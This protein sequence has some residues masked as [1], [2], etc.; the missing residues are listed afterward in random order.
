MYL[1]S[2]K[3]LYSQRRFSWLRL[4]ITLLVVAAGVYIGY[5]L[6]GLF[7][8]ETPSMASPTPMPT[9]TPSAGLYVAQAEEAYQQGSFGDAIA[10]YRMALDLQPNQADL[11][12]ELARLLIFHGSP[13]RGLDMAREALR[14]QPESA[15]AWAVL[16]LA[17]DWLGVTD[18]AV[19]A[20]ERAVQLSPTLP[21]AYAYLAE[22]YSDDGQWFAAN[23]AIATAL[24]LDARNMDVLRVRAYVLENQGNYYGAIQAYREALQS[25][26]E[27]A[28]IHIAI[29]RNAAALGDLA[30][31]LQAY[32]DAADADPTSAVALDQLGWIQLLV[33][34]YDGARQSLQSAL[35]LQPDLPD[36]YGHLAI[37]HFQQRNYE[38]AIELF[39]SAVKLGEARARRRS[40]F[41][42][43][44]QEPAG[45]LGDRPSG[46]E[47][48]RA[49]FVHPEALTSPLRGVVEGVGSASAIAGYIRLDVTTGGYEV[50]LTN[51][52]PVPADSTY[53]G[54][55]VPLQAPER[56]TVRTQPLFPASDGR[57]TLTGSTGAVKGPPIETYYTLALSY[58]LLDQCSDA[59]PYAQT[60]LRLDPADENALRA[61]ELC[62][63]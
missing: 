21:E 55:F 16:C 41:F 4:T 32:G 59:L 47:I 7:D 61:L 50:S 26:Q 56:T 34:N 1:K 27:L 23:G 49:A 11:Y 14:R 48:A 52:P 30:T 63:Q 17:Y 45:T 38:D 19:A 53:V 35:N 31:A 20:C 29:G 40:V 15:S 10:A 24:E 3:E 46:P 58:Y 18:E 28:H 12:T 5:S 22:A 25:G 6:I 54:W 62:G 13:E 33:G 39:S 60:A 42:V 44:T 8:G 2:P 9:P 36:A 51:V 37:L 43:L 57:A